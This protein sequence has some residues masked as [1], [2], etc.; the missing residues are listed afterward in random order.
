[1]RLGS[2]LKVA[3]MFAL[4]VAMVGCASTQISHTYNPNNSRA[5]NIAHAGGITRGIEDAEVPKDSTYKLDNS[6]LHGAAQAGV[7]VLTASTLGLTDLA[8]GIFGL[9]SVISRA[10]HQGERTSIFAFMPADMA[11][12]PDEASL[13]LKQMFTESFNK[14]FEETF[15][16]KSTDIY[17]NNKLVKNNMIYVFGGDDLHCPNFSIQNPLPEKV[18]CVVSYTISKPRLMHNLPENK[19]LIPSENYYFFSAAPDYEYTEFSFETRNYPTPTFKIISEFSKN[20]PEWVY[21]Y[22]APKTLKDDQGKEIKV[23]FIL[24]KGKVEFFV[25]PQKDS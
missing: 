20:L 5:L 10:P 1:M 8:G 11:T 18:G 2:T 23:P 15:K 12:S 24:N 3:T 4:S 16:T 25:K 19:W 6:Y 13:K 7:G 14:V 9:L 17:D 22:V 21:I